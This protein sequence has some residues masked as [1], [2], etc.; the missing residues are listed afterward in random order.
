MT[1]LPGRGLV[2]GFRLAPQL[3]NLG[4][5]A[6]LGW[7]TVRALAILVRRRPRVVVSV[8]G[9]ASVPAGLA[10]AVL[11]VPLVLVNV[12]ARPGLALSLIHISVL[13]PARSA[14]RW[15]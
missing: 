3:A 13:L 2:R 15:S 8:G 9:Y 10:A 6:G 7:A 11:R 1:L 14:E 4:A 12:D 5:L